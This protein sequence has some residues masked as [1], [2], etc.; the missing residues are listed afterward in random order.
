MADPATKPDRVKE[1]LRCFKLCSE[2]ED[3][4]RQREIDDLEFQVPENQWPTDVQAAREAQTVGLGQQSIV[5][6]ARPM[7]SVPTLDQPIQLVLNQERAASLG[8]EVHPDSEDAT[9]DTAEVLDGLYRKI[10]R[11]SRADLARTWAF[12]RAVK[13]GRGAYRVLT[14]Y[15]PNGGHS[16]DQ[17]IVIKRI[18]RQESVFFDPFAQEPDWSDGEWAIIIE[19]I[20]WTRYKRQFSTSTVAGLNE[21]DFVALG[22]ETPGWAVGKEEKSRTVRV[23]EHFYIE[24]GTNK[25]TWT[26]ADGN[27]QSR[28]DETRVVKWCK[29]N[30]K[31]VLDEGDWE[32]AYIPIIPVIGRELIPFNAERRWVGI[33]GPNKG[34]AR[35]FNYAASGAVEAAA[36]EPKAP[37]D[38]DPEEIEGYEAWWAQANVR[39]FPFLPRKKYLHGQ[40]SGEVHRLQAD[41]SK[42][43][44]NIMLLEKANEFLQTGTAAYKPVLGAESSQGKSGRAILSLQQQH[45][46]GNSNWVDNL[47]QL[48]MTYE[49]RVVL[50]KIPYVYDRPGRV[51]RILDAE[52]KPDVAMLNQPHT[53]DPTTKQPIALPPGTMPPGIPSAGQGQ[54]P[55]AAAQGPIGQPQQ[56]Q[57]KVLHYDLKKGRYAVTVSVGKTEQSRVQEGADE[58]G[59]LFQAE[60]QLFNLLGDIYLKFRDFPGHLEA[61]ERVKK[62]LP[63]PLQDQNGPD[64]AAAQ[65]PQL[66]AQLQAQG[67]QL[68]QAA[69]YIKTEQAKHDAAIQ[70]AN[71]QK[72]KDIT[73]AQMKNA[74]SMA[75]AWI[76]ARA[77]GVINQQESIDEAIALGQQHAHDAHQALL[78]RAHEVGTTAMAGQ[79]ASDQSQQEHQQGQEASQQDAAAQS[80]QSAQEHGQTLEAGAEGHDQ[81]M[82]QQQAAAAQQPESGASA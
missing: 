59:Q 6:P 28:S 3:K 82:E 15:D 80:A 18:L 11:D 27:E 39:N 24:Y 26:D 67:Q 20:P 40:V 21:E 54:T 29:V 44:L 46:A 73:L 13:C 72:E 69:E 1:A 17:K 65:V 32:G 16:S 51:V 56:P 58:L 68:Q 74:A 79:Q 64:A 33:I 60:P 77:K 31:E 76:N 71:I 66:Q 12:E 10:Q 19:D 9:D 78:D 63:P 48:S 4:Q 8:C 36:L 5:L 49:A 23:A 25:V 30:A 75:V 38:L 2:A 61:A 42:T 35:L 37:F 81:A 7:I 52:G 70:I 22:M 41:T 43:Q 62:M 55:A 34:A 53:L 14:E 57:P 50:D 45:D 47:A